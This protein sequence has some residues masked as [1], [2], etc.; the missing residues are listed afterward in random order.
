MVRSELAVFNVTK[1]RRHRWGHMGEKIFWP[2]STLSNAFKKLE[3]Q[4]ASAINDSSL[5][6]IVELPGC[7]N[8]GSTSRNMPGRGCSLFHLSKSDMDTEGKESLVVLWFT[9]PRRF[10]LSLTPQQTAPMLH[11]RAPKPM[12]S[13]RPT[14]QSLSSTGRNREV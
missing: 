12:V 10:G 1:E 11:L 6:N 13:W 4:L 5:I 7:F 3:P 14:V 8:R 2:V 9:T